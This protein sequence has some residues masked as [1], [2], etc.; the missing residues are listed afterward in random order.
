MENIV[1]D[2]DKEQKDKAAATAAAAAE[3]PPAKPEPRF[4]I[5]TPAAAFR[6]ERAGVKF[7]EGIGRTNDEA[8]AGACLG[9]GYDVYDV[10]AK[11]KWK[12]EPAAKK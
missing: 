10:H 11:R 9:F 7:M 1:E 2:K 12:P 4:E 8:A 6:G 5:R 3:L